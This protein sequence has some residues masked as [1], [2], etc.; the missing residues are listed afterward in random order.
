MTIDLRPVREFISNFKLDPFNFHFIGDPTYLPEYTDRIENPMWFE[1]VEDKLRNN[2]Y[3]NN[4]QQWYDD[5]LLIYENALTYN[6][7]DENIT[8]V[9][10]Y[11][12]HKFK[13]EAKKFLIKDEKEW[14]KKVTEKSNELAKLLDQLRIENYLF[15][16]LNQY[17]SGSSEL[18]GVPSSEVTS[19]VDSMNRLSQDVDVREEIFEILK[20]TENMTMEMA[21]SRPIDFESLSAKTQ[22]TLLKYIKSKEK[23]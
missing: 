9:I 21:A 11:L 5:V 1:K 2:E 18:K 12:M 19:L 15:G 4:P 22:N 3:K 8:Q 20:E 10:Y 7:N 16:H 17:I 13:R 6:E 14:V 23:G